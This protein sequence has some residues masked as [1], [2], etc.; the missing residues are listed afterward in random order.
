MY[1]YGRDWFSEDSDG[2]EWLNTETYA[3]WVGLRVLNISDNIAYTVVEV[4]KGA[5]R[6]RLVRDE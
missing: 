2:V 5:N 6:A 1:A 4:D 3:V